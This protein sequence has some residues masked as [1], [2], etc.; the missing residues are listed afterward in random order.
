MLWWTVAKLGAGGALVIG[1]FLAGNFYGPN[2]RWRAVQEAKAQA[3]NDA[4]DYQAE[5]D[6]TA[7]HSLDVELG[8]EAQHFKD[9]T[10]GL[11]GCLLTQAQADAVNLVK[12]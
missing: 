5:H 4:V 8:A 9:A 6:E 2:A 1:L 7:L 3:I 12:D 10:K 11:P